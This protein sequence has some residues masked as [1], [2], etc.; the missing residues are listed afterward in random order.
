M[1]EEIT[2][3]NVAV[4]VGASQAL[5]LSL[6]TL[7]S[8]GD[9]V[10]IFEPYFDLY[11]N[12]I[13]LAG[14]IPVPV[15]LDYAVNPLS[16]QKEWLLNP[17]TLSNS[18][19]PKTRCLIFNSPHNPTGKVFTP[20]EMSTISSLL[21]PH[22]SRITLLSDEVYKYIIHSPP[23]SSPPTSPPGHTMISSL[24]PNTLTIS[25]SGKTFSATG[26]QVGWIIGP[27]PLLK[28][29]KQ[30]LPYVQF[31]ACSITQDALAKALPLSDSTYTLNGI[32][33]K[34]YYEYLKLS[35][36]K[37][38][39]ALIEALEGAGFG[40]PDYEKV[41]GG[42]F[43]IFAEVTEDIIKRVKESTNGKEYFEMGRTK[44]WALCE[45]FI[46]E[47]GVGMIPSSP[48]F[49]EER[50]KEGISEKFVRVAFCGEVEDIE[51]AGRRIRCKEGGDVEACEI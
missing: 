45:Y 47:V 41:G 42:G 3:E 39:D 1:G 6:Q 17:T 48:F 11:I 34:D 2:E 5:Y 9:E 46:K 14:G 8:P 38:R 35:Y 30:M 7:I 23:P 20:S 36:V 37:R 10:L 33:Y 29:I 50:V 26:W 25:S 44:D 18:I 13:K 21:L 49:S 24:Y 15:P 28:P 40:V 51:E 22:S 32:V 16:G 12:Q 19:T 43:F 27:K 4:T 31:C